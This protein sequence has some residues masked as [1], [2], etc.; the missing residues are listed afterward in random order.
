VSTPARVRVQLFPPLAERACASPACKAGCEG[1]GKGP[2]HKTA[3]LDLDA[4]RSAL[5]ND[6]ADSVDLWVAD[7]STDA[8]R[9]DAIERINRLLA[10]DA[11]KLTVSDESLDEFLAQSA[12]ILA[13]GE[14][15][16]SIIVLPTRAGLAELLARPHA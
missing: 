12:P 7:Y 15:I 16:T 9:A 8:G 14:R 4:I 10:V 5:E 11:I 2:A 6:F 3:R 13:V 1:C